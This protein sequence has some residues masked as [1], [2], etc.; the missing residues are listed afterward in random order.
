M[1]ARR[2]IWP[3]YAGLLCL[4]AGLCF[5]NL[6]THLLDTHDAE[7]F[8]D[9]LRI[10]QDWTLFFSPDKE[11]A[12]GRPTAEAVKYLVFLLCGN[13]PAA[14]HL[15]SIAI[16][17]LAALLLARVVFCLGNSA[18]LAGLTGLR[19]NLLQRRLAAEDIWAVAQ[20]HQ[21]GLWMQGHRPQFDQL[22]DGLLVR[23]DLPTT[24][25]LLAMLHKGPPT[26]TR[27]LDFLLN[28]RGAPRLDLV[29]LFDQH[30]WW[31][32][33][34]QYLRS[35]GPDPPPFWVWADPD[36]EAFQVEVLRDWYLVNRGR[37]TGPAERQGPA[38]P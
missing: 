10:Q 1:I 21:L 34:K 19:S 25:I 33:L 38:P 8:R 17:T 12:S 27:A 14:F 23:E 36:L 7:T 28:P 29:Q 24:T 9:H 37:L 20:I 30:R 32:V 31:F 13:D 11:Q 3:G 18:I 26:L 5:G 6:R 16:H 22:V 35:V 15:L 4:V 2:Y